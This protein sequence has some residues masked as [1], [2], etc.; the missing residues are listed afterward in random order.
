MFLPRTSVSLD[1]ESSKR[2][3]AWSICGPWEIRHVRCNHS[4]SCWQ[5]LDPS[6]LPPLFDSGSRRVVHPYY[7]IISSDFV[8][9][10]RVYLRKTARWTLPRSVVTTYC[11]SLLPWTWWLESLC[12]HTNT[13]H[14]WLLCWYYYFSSSQET[15]LVCFRPK[16]II[17]VLYRFYD[18]NK[19]GNV[20]LG[21]KN[22]PT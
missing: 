20:F 17:F 1:S 4:W 14:C 3:L 16:I 19:V 8:A 15:S 2:N 22:N 10:R 6:K 18:L 5:I 12:R 21:G 11:S 7:H 13:V 9:W